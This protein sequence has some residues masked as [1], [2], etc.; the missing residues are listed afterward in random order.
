MKQGNKRKVI[1]KDATGYREVH[2]FVGKTDKNT[3]NQ[4][5]HNSARRKYY[6]LVGNRG[7]L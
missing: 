7:Q 3:E 4:N 1:F 2:I 5:M 6:S